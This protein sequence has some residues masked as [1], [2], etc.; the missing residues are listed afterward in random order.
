MFF[1]SKFKEKAINFKSLFCLLVSSMLWVNAAV[2]QIATDDFEVGNYISGSGAWIGGW[3][4][5]NL[6]VGG[7][8]VGAGDDNPNAD[9]IQIVSNG[10]NELRFVGVGGTD[11]FIFR[12]FNA[13]G[14]SDVQLSYFIDTS[15][16]VNPLDADD[17]FDVQVSAN[18]GA[19][20]VLAQTHVDDVTGTQT[21]DVLGTLGLVTGN[22]NMAI[23]FGIRTFVFPT[24]FFSID[25]VVIF[26]GDIDTDGDSFPDVSDVDDDNDGILDTDESAITPG[27]D[28]ISESPLGTISL[29]STLGGFPAGICNDGNTVG[30]GAGGSICHTDD[31]ATIYDWLQIDLGS[32]QAIAE[33]RIFNRDECCEERLSNAYLIISDTDFTTVT[34]GA[35]ET[36]L[37]GLNN[38]RAVASFEHQFGAVTGDETVTTAGVSGRYV[39]IQL[40]GVGN[41]GGNVINLAEVQVVGGNILADVDSDSD[42][43]FDRLDIDSDND[44]IPDNVE[45]Q[46]TASYQAPTGVD[47][48]GDGLDNQYEPN[49]LGATAPDTDGQGQPDYLDVDSDQDGLL[50]AAE[51]IT[52]VVL[53]N[54]LDTGDTDNDGL[55]NSFDTVNTPGTLFD[56]N[57]AFNN[58]STDLPDTD[59]GDCCGTPRQQD[60]DYRDL[61][62]NQTV[63]K[64]GTSTLGM[65]TVSST[66]PGT[67]SVNETDTIDWVVRYANNTGGTLRNVSIDDTLTGDHTEV[68]GSQQLP[69]GWVSTPGNFSAPVVPNSPSAGSN[70]D[71]TALQG[72]VNVGSGGGDGFAPIIANDRRIYFSFHHRRARL[73]CVNPFTGAVCDNFDPTAGELLPPISA[74][75][76]GYMVDNAHNIQFIGNRLYYPVTRAPIG[77]PLNFALYD[78]LDWGLGCVEVNQIPDPENPPAINPL[79]TPCADMNNVAG[80]TGYFALGPVG[81]NPTNVRNGGIQGPFLFDGRLYLFDNGATVHC[82]DPATAGLC[83]GG[84][85]MDFSDATTFPRIVA[86]NGGQNTA[87]LTG[88]QDGSRMYFILSYVGKATSGTDVEDFRVR[89]FDM[90]TNAECAGWSGASTIAPTGRVAGDTLGEVY[91]SF[92]RR[93]TA[94]VVNALCLY[95]HQG[96]VGCVQT[97]NGASIADGPNDFFGIPDSIHNVLRLDTVID[98]FGAGNT[99]TGNKGMLHETTI[100]NRMYF[101]TFF[102]NG[103]FCWDWTTDDWCAVD[104]GLDPNGDGIWGDTPAA[105]AFGSNAETGVA[106]L[107]PDQGQNTRDY[108]PTFDPVSGCFWSLGDLNVLWNFDGLGNNPCGLNGA[109]GSTEV[110]PDEFFCGSGLQPANF[111]WNELFLKEL[112]LD[113]WARAELQFFDET[114]FANDIPLVSCDFLAVPTAGPFPFSDAAGC[115][116]S[117]RVTLDV[118]NMTAVVPAQLNPLTFRF[119]GSV[120][121]GV[122]INSLERNPSVIMTFNSTIATELCFQTEIPDRGACAASEGAD[123]FAANLAEVQIAGNGDFDETAGPVSFD[124]IRGEDLSGCPADFGDAP[125]SFGTLVGDALAGPGHAIVP[126]P[127]DNPVAELRIG[128]TVEED[129]DG[130][131]GAAADGDIDDGVT[132]QSFLDGGDQFAIQATVTGNNSTGGDAMLCGY[133]DGAADA[134]TDGVFTRAINYTTVGS[135]VGTVAAGNEEICILVEEAS[136]AA[137]SFIFSGIP[138][139][140][141][142]EAE[143]DAVAANGDFTCRINFRPHFS[144][145]GNTIARFRLTSDP[146]FFSNTSP[147]PNG[148]AIDG[149]VEDYFISFNP[150]SVTI[151]SVSLQSVSAASF[152]D[153]LSGAS[154]AELYAILQ[155]WDSEL[156]ESVNPADRQAILQA[157]LQFLD[158][159]GNGQLALLNWNT[160][161]ER[162]T[163]GFH[164]ERRSGQHAW[165]RI[166]Q[167]MLPGLITAP[168]GGEYKLADPSAEAGTN[169]EYKLIEI[170]A[171]GRTNEYGP[172]ELKI[173]ENP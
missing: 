77:Q 71:L 159:D 113:E 144:S 106:F 63:S 41:D 128:G 7:D 140:N 70:I 173:E 117:D 123:A 53:P 2:A 82:F 42:G 12:R 151:G 15:A 148:A 1:S 103:L 51:R 50:D 93:D 20:W 115:V 35:L 68:P 86:D 99:F 121:T 48:D 25:D 164:V 11:P 137:T 101:G 49:G 157:L 18:G 55:I 142:G 24:E 143:C 67:G 105:T 120:P 66:A 167:S 126:N 6:G 130:Q 10:D 58:P 13:A 80:I 30:T 46:L 171:T 16:P 9:L 109:T 83:S 54:I 165:V 81:Y 61:S 33:V 59:G 98:N 19:T 5:V 132:F 72:G 156:S 43:I 95:S 152:L 47:G 135:G 96:G 160:L 166:N 161:E 168:L 158:P 73:Q 108:G 124:I 23:R 112:N 150:T 155:T 154:T 125:S 139:A 22:A 127:N 79:P 119:S 172:F 75:T 57:D 60:V 3:D 153:S 104:A 65:V 89:C 102:K 4:E 36:S 146:R 134:T 114:G 163:V 32:T 91:E 28:I 85:P 170:E 110:R 100:G 17:I 31:G 145:A 52:P 37:A 40:S 39:R 129:A 84:F 88:K 78:P 87:Q 34:D 141:D 116:F 131:P 64:Q 162:G 76:E 56:V 107:N 169:Y 122:D 111:S 94:G 74:T 149:E 29:S 69:P 97:S 8:G 38:A 118:E 21:V 136:G 133:L 27:T 26:N 92:L 147:S 14:E 45:A 90:A 138:G 62:V 44:G